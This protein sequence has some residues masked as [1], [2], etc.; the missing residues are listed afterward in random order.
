LN[1]IHQ[2]NH[3]KVFTLGEYICCE[4]ISSN[5]IEPFFQPS[6]SN[7][8]VLDCWRLFCI[9]ISGCF[10]NDPGFFD[11]FNENGIRILPGLHVGVFEDRTQSHLS[12]GFYEKYY[13]AHTMILQFVLD[14]RNL[15]SLLIVTICQ[16]FQNF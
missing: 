16:F 6:K 10:A 13:I 3:E 1:K 9:D 2:S 8:L 12:S 5:S 4:L 14:K 7:I 15:T 11:H